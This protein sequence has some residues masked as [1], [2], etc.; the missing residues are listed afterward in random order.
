MTDQTDET[1]LHSLK[2]TKDSDA[3]IADKVVRQAPAIARM[4]KAMFDSYVEAGFSE[5][6]AIKLCM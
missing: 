2:T 4:K 5:E 3:A 1:N 6:Q